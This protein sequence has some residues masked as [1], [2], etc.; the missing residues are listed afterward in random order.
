MMHP[1]LQRR[2]VVVLMMLGLAL[3][4]TVEEGYGAPARI[5]QQAYVSSHSLATVDNSVEADETLISVDFNR[6]ALPSALREVAR[7]A[8]L[9][10]SFNPEIV[11]NRLVTLQAERTPVRDVL[12]K[13]LNGTN[14][15]IKI[16]ASGDVIVIT[17]KAETVAPELELIDITVQGQVLDAETREPLPGVTVVVQGTTTGV[18]TD[19]DGNY[20]ITAPEDGSLVFSYVGYRE[21][22]IP[23]ENRSEINVELVAEVAALDEVV[24]TALGIERDSRSLGY[25]ATEIDPDETTV[26]R[27]TNFVQSLQGKLPGVNIAG[28]STGAGG[29]SHLQ[30][31]GQS[32]F[33]GNNRPLIVVDGVPIDNTRNYGGTQGTNNSDGGDGLLSINPDAIESMT[34][35]KGAAAAALYGS[36]AKDGVIMI[37]TKR[38]GNARSGIDVTFNSNAT[39]DSAIDVTNFQYDYGQGEQGKRPTE[40]WPDSGVWSFGEKIEPGMTQVLFDGEVIPYAPQRNQI[41]EFYDGGT[42]L[43]NTLT[44]ATGGTAGG[45]SLTLSGLNNTGI[46][47]NSGFDRY[48]VNLGFTQDLGARFNVSGNVNYSRERHHNPPQLSAQDM[49]ST[50]TIHTMANTMPLELLEKYQRDEDGNEIVWSRFRNRTNP[51]ISIYD[52]FNDIDRDRVY[53]NLTVRYDI[54]P[55]LYVQGRAGQDYYARY[56]ILNFPSLMAGIAPAPSGFVNGTVNQDR[57]TF[58]ETNADILVGATR[59][60]M[61]RVG[62][63]VTAGGNI[64]RRTSDLQSILGRDFIVPFLYTI[65]NSR[66][67]EPLYQYSDR[68]VNSLYAA[69]DF[70][71]N[72]YLYLTLTGRNDWFSTLSPGNRS[73]FYP[74]I[75]GSFVFSDAFRGMPNWLTSGRLRAAYAEVGSDTDVPPFAHTLNYNLNSSLFEG[76]N[77]A[78]PMGT[79]AASVV[80]NPALRPMRLKEYEFGINLYLLNRINMDVTYYNRY[81]IDQILEAAVSNTSGFQSQRINVGESVSRGVE[82]LFGISPIRTAS[83]LWDLSFNVAY[84]TSEVLR[85]GLDESAVS[86]GGRISHVV[87][88]PI[89]QIY[90]F[91]YL[92]D[93][94]GRKVFNPNNGLPLQ[95]S[96][97]VHMGNAIPRW[98]GGI[99]NEFQYKGF[100][101]SALIDFKLGHDLYSNSEFDYVRHGKHKKTLVGREQGYV[102]GDGVLP[103]GS[104]NTIQVPVQTYYEADARVQGS[105]IYNAGF[106]KLRQISVGYDLSQLISRIYPVRSLTVSAVANNVA[107]LKRWTENIDPEQVFEADGTESH[108]LPLTR[109][110]G[111]NVKVQI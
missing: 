57:R 18:T 5:L 72:D 51:Y 17:D 95:T 26:N 52:A 48:N 76:P 60:L 46:T 85:L 45:V 16:P 91:D 61:D 58:R 74:S 21:Q 11:P 6:T 42:T 7:K 77:G 38:A 108:A 81:S 37:T 10:Y 13:L 14:L 71:F 53:G 22:V 73:I 87:G 3:S 99:N 107:T 89:A 96:E 83:T 59:N 111:F 33:G 31:R 63:T 80:P 79:I 40:P 69:T 66:V 24:V 35:L 84:N 64:M 106:W 55:W 93:E 70:S 47:P 41:K 9:G 36:R 39:F 27:T 20:S 12:A 4:G 97:R 75:S 110:I 67:K 94:Q 86:I 54:K 101:A 56:Q 19:L 50:K 102:I 82:A 104:P 32:S 68:Q 78:Q 30:I 62:I 2:T 65:A 29:S 88:Q 1:T 103:D 105:H 100:H 28:M 44:L 15:E 34:V 49:T 90:E 23:I 43:T 92:R 98:I 109:S 8:R 25:S